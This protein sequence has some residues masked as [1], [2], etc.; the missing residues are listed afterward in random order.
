MNEG[1]ITYRHVAAA[2][3]LLVM[4]LAGEAWAQQSSSDASLELRLEVGKTALVLGEPA[5]ATVH[6]KNVGKAPA[7]VFKFL[8]PQ[9]GAVHIDLSSADKPR[10]SFLP[11]F[12][13]DGVGTRTALAPGDEVAAAFPIFYGALGWSFAKPGTYASTHGSPWSYDTNVPLAMYG[14]NWIKAGKYGD[15]EVVDLAR[16]IAFI[17]NVRPPNG[18]EGRVLSDAMN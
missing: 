5:Y 4:L 11:L 13:T 15:S 17:L 12:Y 9:T 6:I 2:T 14:P 16:T 10:M 7:D 8:D 3:L 1:R 18:C